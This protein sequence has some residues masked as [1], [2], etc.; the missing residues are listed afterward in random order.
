MRG[1]LGCARRRAANSS[2]RMHSPERACGMGL[3]CSIDR[4]ARRR[5]RR[6]A[7]EEHGRDR[8]GRPAVPAAGR[9]SEPRSR[10]RL[11]EGSEEDRRRRRE[12]RG[13][14]AARLSRA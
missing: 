7:G 14:P 10:L 8:S 2:K 11:G 4:A 1:S 13:R 3:E 6:E 12:R 5:A 9:R